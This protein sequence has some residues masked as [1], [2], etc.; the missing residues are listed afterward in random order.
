VRIGKVI[1]RRIRESRNGVN[2]VGDVNAVISGNVNE[3]GRSHAIAS[4]NTRIVQNSAIKKPK[5]V[6]S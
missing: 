6:D 3:P 1:R 4:Q 2:I 5:E